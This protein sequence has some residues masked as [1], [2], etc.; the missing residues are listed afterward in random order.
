MAKEDKKIKGNED[1]LHGLFRETL[2]GLRDDLIETDENVQL[3]L[4]AIQNDPG[5][6]ELYGSLYND[7]LKIKGSARDR[8]LKF[9]ALYKDR[10]SKKEDMAL[11]SNERTGSEFSIDHSDLNDLVGKIKLTKIEDVKGQN[12]IPFIEPK[13][14]IRVGEI[15]E[16]LDEIEEEEEF[17]YED[18]TENDYNI[19]DDGEE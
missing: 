6:K 5:G 11:K 19:D 1:E 12:V 3:Y 18:D 10:V 9:L 2:D 17:D 8:T 13:Q 4:D 14:T 16:D 7:A 15:K